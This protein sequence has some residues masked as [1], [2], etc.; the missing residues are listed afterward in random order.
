MEEELGVIE[1]VIHK[2]EQ[3]N[4]DEDQRKTA[5]TT[6]VRLTSAVPGSLPI[7]AGMFILGAFPFSSPLYAHSRSI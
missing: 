1:R 5:A 6:G 3:A 7:D 4:N 2:V